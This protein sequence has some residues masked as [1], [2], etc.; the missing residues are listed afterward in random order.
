MTRWAG[1]GASPA[2]PRSPRKADP[3]REGQ[4]DVSG[5]LPRARSRSQAIALG[6]L[7]GGAAGNL[8]DRLLRAPGPGVGRVV[9]FINYHGWFVGNVADIAIVAS[10][11]L[12]I[13]GAMRAPGHGHRVQHPST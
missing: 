2:S 7:A 6:L 3:R 8:L 10:A 5:P 13:L 4:D 1:A 9:D 11:A 12:L